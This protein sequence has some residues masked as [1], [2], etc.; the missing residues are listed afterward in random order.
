M[1]NTSPAPYDEICGGSNTDPRFFSCCTAG[2]T[3]L[4]GGLCYT[5]Q[6]TTRQLSQYYVGSCTDPTYTDPS[7]P[8]QCTDQ[9]EP[10]IVFSNTTNLWSC[11]NGNCPDPS[12]ETFSASAP[13]ALLQATMTPWTAVPTASSAATSTWN[14]GDIGATATAASTSY[15]T[16]SYTSTDNSS[17]GP[18]AGSIVGI[19]VGVTFA[20]FV[21]VLVTCMARSARR[22][23]SRSHSRNAGVNPSQGHG[24]AEQVPGAP[25]AYGFVMEQLGEKDRTAE[26]V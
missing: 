5:Q 15:P 17:P 13:A 18:D 9:Q 4:P 20:V 7:C 22:T 24:A 12:S 21:V 8:Q 19:A 23:G 10:D 26:S 3:C 14:F 2:D 1:I 16:S 11:C 25:P 6:P